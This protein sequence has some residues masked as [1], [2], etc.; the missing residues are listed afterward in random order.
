MKQ[1]GT[2]AVL[3]ALLPGLGQLYNGTIFR[4]IFWFIVTPGLWIGTGGTLGWVCHVIAAMTAYNYAT[5]YTRVISR[6]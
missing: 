2:A 4:A 5:R 3:S 1:P 6:P